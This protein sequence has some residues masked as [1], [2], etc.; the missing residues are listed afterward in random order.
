M[1]NDAANLPV[2]P[3]RGVTGYPNGD[4]QSKSLPMPGKSPIEM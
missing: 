2:I 1:H 3:P 4:T